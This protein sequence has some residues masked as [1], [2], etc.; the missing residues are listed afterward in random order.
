MGYLAPEKFVL[1][2]VQHYLENDEL[3]GN[4]ARLRSAKYLRFGK[5]KRLMNQL[6]FG[7]R[8]FA[9]E[10]IRRHTPCALIHTALNDFVHVESHLFRALHALLLMCLVHLAN[11]FYYHALNDLQWGY[12]Q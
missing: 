1:L 10:W 5:K 12:L 6:M 3:L 9:S 11:L 2:G 8:I 7:T 4:E